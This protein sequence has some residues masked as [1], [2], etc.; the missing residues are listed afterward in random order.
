MP[1]LSILLSSSNEVPEL[2]TLSLE[3]SLL[4]SSSSVA[5]F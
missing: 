5:V 1:A 3:M 4:S 2:T